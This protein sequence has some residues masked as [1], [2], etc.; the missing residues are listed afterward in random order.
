MATSVSGPSAA[1]A[2]GITG[3]TGVT[4]TAPDQAVVDFFNTLE[5]GDLSIEA[6]ISEAEANQAITLFSVVNVLLG[7]SSQYK[8]GNEMKTDVLGV[9]TLYYGLQDK[10]LTHKIVVRSQDL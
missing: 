10:S 3:I 5:S 4:G 8:V 2:T 6:P 9:L 1:A 7:G